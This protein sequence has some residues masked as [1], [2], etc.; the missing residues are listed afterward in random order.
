MQLAGLHHA[1]VFVKGKLA[2]GIESKPLH[3]I[4]D[5]NRLAAEFGNDLLK[6]RDLP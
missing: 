2:H 6:S 3:D 1:E 5:Q 4:V